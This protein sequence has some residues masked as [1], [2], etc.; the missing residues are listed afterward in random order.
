MN[1]SPA[2]VVLLA[3]IAA[4]P[5]ALAGWNDLNLTSAENLADARQGRNVSLSLAVE[6]LGNSDG[7]AVYLLNVTLLPPP[8][9]N[10]GASVSSAGAIICPKTESSCRLRFPNAGTKAIFN[11]TNLTTDPACVNGMKDY[12]FTIAGNVELSSVES[13]WAPEARAK[14]SSVFIIRFIGPDACGDRAC[15]DALVGGNESCVTCPADCG[16]CPVCSAGQRACRNNSVYSCANGQ[17]ARLVE[18]CAHGCEDAFGGPACRR[19][20]EENETR[21]ADADTLEACRNNDWVRSACPKGCANGACDTDLCR[22]V[23]CPDT[24][25]GARAYSYGACDAASGDC[26]YFDV[27]DCV[28]GC[29]ASLCA[30]PPAAT[31]TPR[32][33]SNAARG[34]GLPGACCGS[35]AFIL[36][37]LAMLAF[38]RRAPSSS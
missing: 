14:N 8:C 10:G 33:T 13:K 28:S 36:L 2:C 25:T 35:A 29:N 26:M 3:L 23:A 16:A 6:N 11:F 7:Y 4:S 24:C 27:H 12:R 19:I 15:A 21:C 34:L 9:V 32:S 38:L 37:P 1:F 20:C 30:A 5:L 17:Y 18:M 31:S 22:G